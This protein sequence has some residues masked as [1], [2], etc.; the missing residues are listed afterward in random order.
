MNLP[1]PNELL[2]AYLLG[3]VALLVLLSVLLSVPRGGLRE[4]PSRAT[5]F[6][7]VFLRLAI[8]WHILVEGLDKVQSSTWSSEAYLREASGPLAPWFRQLAGDPL[9]D[10]LTPTP[11][12]GFP[13][14]LDRDWQNYFDRFVRYYQLDDQQK[15]R[16]EA[17]LD[18]SKAGTLHWMTSET[19]ET[20]KPSP[21][22]SALKRRQ[23]VPERLKE[24]DALLQE[25]LR[26]EE[27]ELPLFGT[28]SHKHYLEV[29]ADANRVRN[30]LKK[31]LAGQTA[32]M[33]KALAEV[34]TTE[35]K[36]IPPVPDARPYPWQAS[37]LLPW[38][39]EIVRW[40]LVVTGVCLLLGLFTRT[41]CVAGA[42]FLLLFY[43][44]MIPLPYWPEPPRAEGHYIL[45]NKNI[46]EML[47]LLA[48]ATTRSGRWAGLDGLF[49]L[50]RRERGLPR[51]VPESINPNP[52]TN[53]PVT[54]E[55][56]HGA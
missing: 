40:G 51:T 25:L 21:S 26:I 12:N 11:D 54:K 56:A 30:D 19:T 42:V 45:L 4:G 1:V 43:L 15:S 37:G 28:G 52:T 9:R 13:T 29:K 27:N 20:T 6:F 38:A 22:G 36:R 53:P 31:D 7:L 2:L 47:A 35:Q 23:T 55:S 39:D 46:I 10:R 48:L 49:A 5:R 3:G 32:Q 33:K 14:A 18:Q 34:L 8:G 24:Y 17:I 50:F 44:A 16:A 41:A